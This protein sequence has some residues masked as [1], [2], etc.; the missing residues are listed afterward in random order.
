MVNC[1]LGDFVALIVAA[2]L[3]VNNQEGELLNVVLEVFHGTPKITIDFPV[4]DCTRNS[5]A[6][7]ATLML[8]GYLCLCGF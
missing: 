4:V 3:R 5:A 7:Y 2:L 1:F 6:K 8:I